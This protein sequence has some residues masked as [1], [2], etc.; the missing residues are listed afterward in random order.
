MKNGNNAVV[1]ADALVENHG[2]LVLLRPVSSAAFDWF[3]VNLPEDRMYF[4]NAVVVE[5]RFLLHIVLGMRD[6][7]LLLRNT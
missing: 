4:G 7:G 6:A 2:S 1:A 5:P 3:E